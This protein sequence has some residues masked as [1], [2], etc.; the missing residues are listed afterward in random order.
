[1]TTTTT[2]STSTTAPAAETKAKGSRPKVLLL[3]AVILVLIAALSFASPFLPRGGFGGGQ[4]PSGAPPANGQAPGGTG[5]P[6]AGQNFTPG[7]NGAPSGLPSGGQTGTRG[8]MPGQ[9]GAFGL[10]SFMQP[11]RIG[12]AV[13]GGLL[14]LF[15]ALGL[16]RLKMW[17][18]NL[19]LVVAVGSLL[20]AAATLISPMLGRGTPWLMLF[21]NSTWLAI[22]GL[23]L[24]LGASTLSLLPAA[25]RAYVVKPKERRV[26]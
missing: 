1:M 12:E 14:A 18:R 6:P 10:M 7:Q 16:W 22:V 11:V 4:P 9:S 25:R 20:T 8:G 5:Q 2:T 17:G 26:A 13:V 24:A 19:A 21:T 15:A 3:A 23:V